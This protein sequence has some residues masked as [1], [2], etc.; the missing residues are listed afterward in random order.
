MERNEPIDQ[1]L[2]WQFPAS[3]LAKLDCLNQVSQMLRGNLIIGV[4]WIGNE[5]NMLFG[6]QCI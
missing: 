4:E 2:M 1:N 3:G 5:E 6:V